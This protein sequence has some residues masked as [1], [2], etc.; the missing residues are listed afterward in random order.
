MQL[1][2]LHAATCVRSGYG[3]NS[4]WL[5]SYVDICSHRAVAA[6]VSMYYVM[7]VL[8]VNSHRQV[9][10]GNAWSARRIWQCPCDTLCALLIVD[11]PAP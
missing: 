10:P 3:S 9:E 2:A 5:S 8:C 6:G 7:Y 1:H 11:E 4:A